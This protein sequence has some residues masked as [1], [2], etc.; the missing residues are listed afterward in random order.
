MNTDEHRWPVIKVRVVPMATVHFLFS[1]HLCSSV[2]ICG[3]NDFL[4]P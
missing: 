4:V 1:S 2:F 3:S